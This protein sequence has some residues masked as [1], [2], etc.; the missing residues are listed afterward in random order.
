EQVERAWSQADPAF[1]PKDVSPPRRCSRYHCAHQDPEQ[2][3]H[4][5]LLPFIVPWKLNCTNEND[6]LDLDDLDDESPTG[7][8]HAA[9]IPTIIR[10]YRAITSL[11]SWNE[12]SS[13]E[14]PHRPPQRTP[15][16]TKKHH[17]H[18]RHRGHPEHQVSNRPG[19][20]D[21]YLSDFYNDEPS[22]EPRLLSEHSY[23]EPG[24]STSRAALLTGRPCR[25]SKPAYQPLPLD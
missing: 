25:Y 12:P 20:Q 3:P 6:L 21:N 1:L 18:D 22:W 23:G 9:S 8:L 14:Y 15:G 11:L 17:R 5:T 4:R 13:P 16:V 7:D 19:N 2:G 10:R 24:P